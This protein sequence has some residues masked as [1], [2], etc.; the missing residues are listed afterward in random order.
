MSAVFVAFQYF[1]SSGGAAFRRE[2]FTAFQLLVGLP[3]CFIWL[4]LEVGL[5]EEFFFRALVQS[6]LAAAFKSE[7][8]GIVLM[9]L[10]F[11]FGARP[12]LYLSPCWRIG[13]TWPASYRTRCRCLLDCRPGGERN[14]VWRYLG[15]NE[16]S[17]CSHARACCRRSGAKLQ[18]L[19]PNVVLIGD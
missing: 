16:K 9:S 15:A 13:R 11:W 8:S 10:I 5:V 19:H 12:R 4:L 14:C 3:L 18:Q 6:Q 7:V 17:F 1:V 2:H